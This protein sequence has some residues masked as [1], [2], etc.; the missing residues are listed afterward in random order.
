MPIGSS[1]GSVGKKG[2]GKVRDDF[3]YCCIKMYI[4]PSLVLCHR[5]GSLNEGGTAYVF[6]TKLKKLLQN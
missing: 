5:D 3:S 6:L 2:W 1:Y 4:V